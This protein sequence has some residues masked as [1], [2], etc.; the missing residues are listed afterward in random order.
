[1]SENRLSNRKVDDYNRNHEFRSLE[2]IYVLV[3]EIFE[4]YLLYYFIEC[5][6]FK[7]ELRHYITINLRYS[8][9][10]NHLSNFIISV[11]ENVCK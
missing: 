5:I 7:E 11:R 8:I 6:H 2:L 3:I 4:N 1:M 10:I 9:L